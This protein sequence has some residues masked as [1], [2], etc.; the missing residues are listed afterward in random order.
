MRAG[1]T[2]SACPKG[3][4]GGSRAQALPQQGQGR[5]L[6]PTARPRWVQRCVCALFVRF[7]RPAARLLAA[8]FWRTLAA[9]RPCARV[10][11]RVARANRSR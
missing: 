2:R 5:A 6:P 10:P 4:I 9:L 8:H 3:K 7:R 11:E 1:R